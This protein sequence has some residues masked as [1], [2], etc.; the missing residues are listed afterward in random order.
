MRRPFVPVIGGRARRRPPPPAPPPAHVV[1]TPGPALIALDGRLALAQAGASVEVTIGPCAIALGGRGAGAAAGVS[2]IPGAANIAHSGRVSG[3]A[4]GAAILAGP[5]AVTVEGRPALSEGDALAT[6]GPSAIAIEGRAPSVSVAGEPALA[7]PG[8]ASVTIIGRQAH[9]SAGV[10]ASPN[11]A[12]VAIEGRTASSH[13]GAQTQPGAASVA[14]DGRAA[15][16]SAAARASPGAAG[17]AVMGRPSVPVMPAEATPQPAAIMIEGRQASAQAGVAAEPD[18]G[19]IAVTGKSSDALAGAS[20]AVG[21][22]AIAIAGQPA[23]ALI[24][25][26]DSYAW[27]KFTI[28]HEGGL[29]A[30]LPLRVS[31]RSLPAESGFFASA[32]ADGGDIRAFA[33]DKETQLPFELVAF[34]RDG[35]KIE[36]WARTQGLDQDEFVWIRTGKGEAS[37]DLDQPAADSEFGSEAVWDG[38]ECVAHALDADSAG[39]HTLSNNGTELIEAQAGLRGRGYGATIGAGATDRTTTS[40]V[41]HTA[42]RSVLFFANRR[43]NGG[44]NLGRVFERAGSPSPQDVFFNANSGARLEHQRDFAGGRATLNLP[45]LGVSETVWTRIAYVEDHSGGYALPSIYIDGAADTVSQAAWS[46][47]APET[48]ASAYYIGNRGDFNRH[49]DGGLG[50]FWI[51]HGAID[52]AFAA[53]DAVQISA[54]ESFVEAGD[55]EGVPD[56]ALANVGAG[57]LAL[58]GK[59][60]LAG[61]GASVTPGAAGIGIEGKPASAGIVASVD[62]TPGA[63]TIAIAGKGASPAAG[64]VAAPGVAAISLAGQALDAGITVVAVPGASQIA[65][66]GKP[67]QS[68]AGA[69]ASPG[70]SA[71]AVEGRPVDASVSGGERVAPS[72]T[73]ATPGTTGGSNAGSVTVGRPSGTANGDLLLASLSRDGSADQTALGGFDTIVSSNMGSHLGAVWNRIASSEPADYT[74]SFSSEMAVLAMLRV[75]NHDGIDASSTPNFSGTNTQ[76]LTVASFNTTVE[77]TRQFAFVFSETG[78]STISPPAGQGWEQISQTGSGTSAAG[79]RLAIYTRVQA[80]AGATGNQTF[81]Q[82]TNTQMG[83]LIVAVKGVIG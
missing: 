46:T 67:A 68:G 15:Q 56:D 63:A 77:N 27:T 51:L 75:Y 42:V 64:A 57:T 66:A 32:Q 13:A 73:A 78:N 72:Y 33:A 60:A 74:A 29:P 1:V 62:A 24:E 19:A 30:L 10:L 20:V 9:P 44:G 61:A 25:E 80:A 49:W 36:G 21:A 34:D 43:G 39:R 45:A 47:G 82:A 71:I 41:D 55:T 28:L 81:T 18:A 83:A 40:A 48:D 31:D 79:A 23:D 5:G 22:A 38:W 12:A 11:V 53:A 52:A 8:K 3:V 70:A 69:G 4:A 58:A 2:V 65:V 50:E 35:E 37:E 59:P 17:I 26:P 14:I 76:E 16:S 7:T 6:P 54:P